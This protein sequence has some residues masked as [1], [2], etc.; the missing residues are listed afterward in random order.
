MKR[1]FTL[2][3]IFCF[4]LNAC[5]STNKKL[6]ATD[7]NNPPPSLLKPVVKKIWIPPAIKNGGAEWEEGHY[8]YRIE[9]ETT[10]SR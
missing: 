3:L 5:V 1:V 8:L 4:T 6:P 7:S 2:F 10:W 9:K